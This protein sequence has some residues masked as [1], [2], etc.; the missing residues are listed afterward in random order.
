MQTFGFGAE[1][2][3]SKRSKSVLAV[4]MPFLKEDRIT[5]NGPIRRFLQF[6]IPIKLNISVIEGY[7]VGYYGYP[8]AT[9]NM[10]IWIAIA[11][12][13]AAKVV[14]VLQ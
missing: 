5:S 13:N 7:A 10:D 4:K 6:S 11:P 1:E 8:R 2:G 12:E 14:K 3:H 9:A